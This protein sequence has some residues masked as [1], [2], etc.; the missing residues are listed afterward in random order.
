M[1]THRSIIDLTL[2]DALPRDGGGV[3][4]PRIWKVVHYRVGLFTAELFFLKAISV[5]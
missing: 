4:A 1:I 3:T 2:I 5:A